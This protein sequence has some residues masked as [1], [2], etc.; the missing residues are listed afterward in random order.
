MADGVFEF[1]MLWMIW[2][3]V[4]QMLNIVIDIADVGKMC[5]DEET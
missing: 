4:I 1:W 2:D 5:T 3:G